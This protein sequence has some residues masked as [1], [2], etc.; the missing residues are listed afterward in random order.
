VRFGYKPW[1]EAAGKPRWD[2]HQAC[3]RMVR[4]DYAGDGIGHTR[5][6]TLIDL[7]HKPVL[8]LYTVFVILSI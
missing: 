5:D 8:P 4:A 1:R 7:L 2:Y 6:G 3:V